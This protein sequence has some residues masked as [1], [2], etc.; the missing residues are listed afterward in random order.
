[1]TPQAGDR[2]GAPGQERRK[3]LDLPF[4]PEGLEGTNRNYL[5]AEMKTSRGLSLTRDS[6]I[7]TDGGKEALAFSNHHFEPLL[8][9]LS[10][11]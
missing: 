8:F 7:G 6:L 2:A 4:H 5:V 10:E 3:Q 9:I 1:M 11:Q